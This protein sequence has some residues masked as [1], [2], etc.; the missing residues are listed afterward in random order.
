MLL[1][2]VMLQNETGSRIREYISGWENA[3]KSTPWKSLGRAGAHEVIKNV[4][5]NQY[6]TTEE[7]KGLNSYKFP[8]IRKRR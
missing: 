8:A 4:A 2:S 5:A 6:V 7:G 1:F 3:P